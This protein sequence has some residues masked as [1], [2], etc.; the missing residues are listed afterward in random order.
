[1]FEA[2]NVRDYVNGNG[3]DETTGFVQALE[4]SKNKTLLIE[5][6]T[7]KLNPQDQ[8]GNW[9]NV[10]GGKR[11]IIASNGILKMIPPTVPRDTPGY[12]NTMLLFGNCSSVD[13]T[14][15][16]VDMEGLP[17]DARGG[18][19]PILFDHCDNVRFDNNYIHDNGF[20]GVTTQSCVDVRMTNNKILNTDAAIFCVGS[21]SGMGRIRI[22]DNFIKGGTSEGIGIFDATKNNTYADLAQNWIISGNTIQGKDSYGMN[23]TAINGI[24]DSN[25]I[26]GC[27]GGIFF[28]G[29]GDNGQNGSTVSKNITVTNNR[30]TDCE[31]G[32]NNIGSGF[33]FENNSF[34]S[35]RQRSLSTNEY[36]ELAA[37]LKSYNVKICN[38]HF[39]DVNSD[40]RAV[41]NLYNL[42]DSVFSDNQIYNSG[43]SFPGIFMEQCENVLVENNYARNTNFTLERGTNFSISSVVRNNFFDNMKIRDV[44]NDNRVPLP[45]TGNWIFENNILTNP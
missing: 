23:I 35:I 6:I 27:L 39:E 44:N 33:V 45:A 36:T 19:S 18:T 37:S 7:I 28:Y 34:K 4:A 8:V 3:T 13:I 5:N 22:T 1:M 26:T 15:L 12:P 11:K 42:V 43:T 21:T 2:I 40:G 17:G 25:T 10:Q 41:V 14:G 38:N 16:E 29:G 32:M 31:S 24:V 9:I 30:V 20:A